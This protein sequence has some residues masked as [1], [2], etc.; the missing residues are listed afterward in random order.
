[1]SRSLRDSARLTSY[2]T[3]SVT[4]ERKEGLVTICT[5]NSVKLRREKERLVVRDESSVSYIKRRGKADSV[6]KYR[7]IVI[8]QGEWEILREFLLDHKEKE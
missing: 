4:T 8:E 2:Q 1:M 7:I 5:R 6:K 3:D